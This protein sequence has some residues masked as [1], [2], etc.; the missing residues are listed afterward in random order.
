MCYMIECVNKVSYM[1]G[2]V[3]KVCCMRGCVNKVY[4][5]RGCVDDPPGLASPSN[6]TIRVSSSI[7]MMP[8]CVERR[9]VVRGCVLRGRGERE[10]VLEGVW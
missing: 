2:C 9:G 1:R 10:G 3:D 5:M 7:I 8:A 4:C 6:T